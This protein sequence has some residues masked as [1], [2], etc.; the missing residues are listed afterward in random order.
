MI[1]NS[2]G[3]T[4]LEIMISIALMGMVG[5]TAATLF[6]QHI[7][8]KTVSENETEMS[9]DFNAFLNVFEIQMSNTTE[10]L[11]CNC[12]GLGGGVQA[13]IFNEA[14]E[15]A[16]T[17]PCGPISGAFPNHQ[18]M[19]DL[20]VETSDTP[21]APAA[22][23]CIA[24]PGSASGIVGRGCKK[25]IQILLENP[26]PVTAAAG[27]TNIGTSGKLKIVDATGGAN[28]VLHELE[29]VYSFKCGQTPT[30]PTAGT[31]NPAGTDFK[32]VIRSK[33]RRQKAIRWTDPNL[34]EGWWP[35]DP[36][37][38]GAAAVADNGFYKGSHREVAS[39][40][41]LRNISQVG[42]YFGSTNSFRGCTADGQT[43]VSGN[44]CSGYM[45][46]NA[47]CLSANNCVTSG[48]AYAGIFD[49]G[50]ASCCSHMADPTTG[51]CI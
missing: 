50:I 10:I 3:M 6:T 30:D 23:G 40:I 12:G 26:S 2:I 39:S 46:E 18:I 43:P 51:N 32:V 11:G 9:E 7:V 16:L 25:N 22:A 24:N 31:Q 34:V 45:D 15:C 14:R 4:L 33:A 36:T 17:Q 42:T 28:R 19:L 41:P 21:T 38:G 13:C 44:C 20:I 29:G 37:S 35:G 49:I 47:V 27:V 8:N 1:T 5:L 48:N